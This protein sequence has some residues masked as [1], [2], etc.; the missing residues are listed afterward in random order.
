MAKDFYTYKHFFYR[1]D[2]LTSQVASQNAIEIRARVKI[3]I[4]LSLI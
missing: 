3:K 2:A 4:G 1:R